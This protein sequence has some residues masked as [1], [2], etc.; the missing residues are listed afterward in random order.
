M[1]NHA[2]VVV[3]GG[4][5]AGCSTLFHLTSE[6]WNDVMLVERDELTSGST[7]H[8]A[9]QVTQF[10]G[11]QTMVALKR[12]SIDLYRELA[13]DEDFPINYH[14]TG[15]MRLGY[16]ERQDD[17]YKHYIGM[18]KGMGV[19]FELIDG[20]EAARRHPLMTAD[21]IRSAWWDPLDGDIDPSQL[22]QALARRARKAG[23]EIVRFN[24]VQALTQK[25]NSEWIVHTKNGD[26]TAEYIVNATGYRVNEVGQMMGV[27]HPV[28]SMEHMYFL[29][30]PIPQLEE[31]D[32]RVPIIR[33]P[34]DDFYSRQEKKGLLVGV[35][36]QGCKTFGMD[37]I[38]PDFTMT[39]CPNDLDRCLDNMERIFERIPALKETGI[40]TIVNGPITYSADGSPLVGRIPGVKNAFACLGLR[41][42]IG[43][44][45][46]HGKILAETIIYGES[47]WD[48]WFLDPRRFTQ[49]ANTNFTM[50][51]SIEDYQMEFHYHEP[52]EFR[53]A[54][55]LAQTTPL[56]PVLKEL[57]AEFGVVNGWERAMFYPPAGFKD[58]PGFR[59]R[60]REGII[61]AEA[62]NVRDHVGI[63]EVSGFTRFAL[64]GANVHQAM[65]RLIAGA[66]PKPGKVS[67]SYLLSAKG[68]VLSEATL[69]HLDQETLWF[70]SAA[71]AEWHDRDWLNDHLG[72][73][74][75]VVNLSASTTTLVLAG[76]KTRD[77]LVEIAPKVDW[78]HQGF[79][80]MSA[81]KVLVG[82][83][84]AVAMRIS[85]SG[86]MAFELHIPNEQLYLIWTMLTAAGQSYGLKPFGLHAAESMRLEKGYRHWKA[87]LMV[88]FNPAESGLDRFINRDKSDY[89]GRDGFE[90]QLQYGLKKRFAMMVVDCDYAPAHAGDGIYLDGAQVG[91]VTSGGYGHRVGK[92]IA[93][94]FIDPNIAEDAQLTIEILSEFCPATITIKA[95]YD[96]ENILMRS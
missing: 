75:E 33:D 8:A 71:A 50:V 64:K 63:M 26:I 9:A 77:L 79:P 12:H 56:Y 49:H 35:Y 19:E 13:A 40:H 2:R 14:I 70:G 28:I 6:G 81:R 73:G 90:K 44:G 76:P 84:E 10:G 58:E 21:G 5:I 17:I 27:V 32:K 18:A 29:T 78:S 1:R 83:A 59:F 38:D 74:V 39:L 88:E 94:G 68:N 82:H 80:F 52:H 53:P 23:A 3:I 11:N 25:P 7:W 95:L 34:G 92:N 86:E 22:T 48:A 30:D 69:A 72:D 89:I 31:M 45:G 41:A 87:D 43:E 91:S 46:G 37:G 55:R 20:A 65:D 54:G 15:G 60:L 4:G 96:P 62:L 51:K 85:F 24:P 66:M 47:E 61:K 67:L 57:N 16:T 36:E 93:F 42:G